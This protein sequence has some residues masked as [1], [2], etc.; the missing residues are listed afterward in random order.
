ME[1]NKR[2]VIDKP[3]NPFMILIALP[4]AIICAI[5]MYILN[6]KFYGTSLKRDK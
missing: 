5:L 3:V 2:P 6:L 1:K 4:I